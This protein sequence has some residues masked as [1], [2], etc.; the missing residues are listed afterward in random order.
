MY[1]RNMFNTTTENTPFGLLLRNSPKLMD[2]LIQIVG[3]NSTSNPALLQKKF[4][5]K[6]CVEARR[7]VLYFKI[8]FIQPKSNIENVYI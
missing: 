2:S 8:L 4:Q 6:Y 5:E 1:M 3:M 7:N